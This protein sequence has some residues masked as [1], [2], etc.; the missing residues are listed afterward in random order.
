MEQK[1]FDL[2]SF[3]GLLLLGAIMLWFMYNNQEEVTPTE[4]TTEIVLD[5]T[6]TTTT[7]TITNNTTPIVT[8][9]S[10]KNVA[11]Q[12][13]LGAFSYGAQVATEGTTI[14]ENKLLKLTIDNKGGQIIEALVK[15]Y[16]KK[17]R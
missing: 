6:K 15:T 10:I 17:R 16:F 5:S 14:L 9:D 13:R 1:K 8:N 7:P 2:N 11:L 12:N 4:N 3:I